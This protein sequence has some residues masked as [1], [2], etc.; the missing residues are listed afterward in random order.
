MSKANPKYPRRA[1]NE[2]PYPLRYEILRIIQ[3]AKKVLH[4][5]DAR[6]Y[7]RR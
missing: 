7:K 3:A 1:D 6:K 5:L 2:G 4:E